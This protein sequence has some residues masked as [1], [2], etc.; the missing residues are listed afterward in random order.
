MAAAQASHTDTQRRLVLCFDGTGNTF[1][2]DASDTNVVKIF[3][4]LDRKNAEQFHYY[5]PGIG[6][7]IEGKVATSQTLLRKIITKISTSIDEAIGTTFADHVTAGYRFLMRYY[8]EGD[9][10]YIFGFSRGAYTARFLAEMI[11]SIG[12]LSRGNEEMVQ[13]AWKTFS[14]FQQTRGHTPLTKA[15]LERR[16]YMVKFKQT[17]CRLKVNIHFLGLFDCV[18]SVGQFEIPLFRK[19]YEVI[20]KPP[21]THIRHAVSI[22]ERRLK[23]KPALFLYDNASP[24]RDIV[25]AWFTGNHGDVGGGWNYEKGEEHLLSDT[26]LVWMVNEVLHLPGDKAKLAFKTTSVEKRAQEEIKF[27][28]DL[29]ATLTAS[30]PRKH[31]FRMHDMLSF[32]MG[33][34]WFATLMWWILELLP[35]FAR[36]ELENGKWIPRHFPPNLGAPR[37]IPKGANIH[38]S[39]YELHQAGYLTDEQLPKMGGNNPH[40]NPTG[41]LFA[42]TQKRSAAQQAAQKSL[43]LTK[44]LANGAL[45]NG[46]AH[47]AIPRGDVKGLTG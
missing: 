15:D 17:F 3:Q 44:P 13:L 42:W 39:V 37:D 18:N 43:E 1:K 19:S 45:A 6:T 31:N 16:D 28:K 35:F 11:H 40:I 25:E 26:P 47:A 41:A 5:Q 29:K 33:V 14:K 2:G 7:Y 46:F 9:S 10:I 30:V 32:G 27:Q 23:F 21:A 20:A 36:L 34:S 12:L 8:A 4:M 38:K 22:H 24:Q